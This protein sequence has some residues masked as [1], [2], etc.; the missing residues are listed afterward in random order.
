METSRGCPYHC[1]FCA[2]DNYRDQYRRRP[3]ETILTELDRLIRQGVGYVYFIDEIFLPNGELLEGLASRRIKI[4]IQ[5]RIDLWNRRMIDLLA[6]AGCVSIEAGIESLTP[7]GRELLDKR[8]KLDTGELSERLVY[9]K[10][11]IPFV[12]GNLI[13]TPMDDGRTVAEWRDEMRAAGVWANDPV[14]MFPYPGSPDYTLRWGAPDD[15]AWER[16]HEYYLA[17]YSRFS[18][19]QETRPRPLHELE[20]A[21]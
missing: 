1:T 11:K 4:G 9:A 20:H 16:A 8:C 5:T 13:K 14:P 10:K 18:D 3:L 19:L 7:E 21:G 12:Q 2:K 6:R 15:F 17:N